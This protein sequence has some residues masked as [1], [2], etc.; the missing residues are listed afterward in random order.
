MRSIKTIDA[1]PTSPPPVMSG[2]S[3]GT[4]TAWTA[5]PRTVSAESRF[6]HS[7]LGGR[8]KLPYYPAPPNR[9]LLLGRELLALALGAPVS[10]KVTVIAFQ[11]AR[12]IRPGEGTP[13]ALDT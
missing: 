13:G 11:V 3:M 4:S 10:H 8:A 2:R 5:R 1:E 9:S 12:I 7:S 6:I